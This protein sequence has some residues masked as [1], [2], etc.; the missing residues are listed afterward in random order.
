MTR[1]CLPII[2]KSFN[3]VKDEI[4][5]ASSKYDLFEVWYDYIENG[6]IEELKV[7]AENLGDKLIVL[8]RRQNL[9]PPKLSLEER[10]QVISVLS[11][12]DSYVDLDFMTQVEELKFLRI[13]SAAPKLIVSYHNYES[14]PDDPAL[15][16]LV[17]EMKVFKPTIIKIAT[18]CEI[19]EDALRLLKLR[20]E[21]ND[22]KIPGIV[23]GMGMRGIA[24]RVFGAIWGN[25]ISFAPESLD[26]ASAAGQLTLKELKECLKVLS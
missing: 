15:R 13:V 24:T 23:L 17:Q 5:A 8:L 25:E 6:S 12:T 1:F 4:Q 16:V 21:L 3:A 19:E 22:L 18:N 11:N 14:T 10:K 7:L 2:N 20:L 9:E 26:K